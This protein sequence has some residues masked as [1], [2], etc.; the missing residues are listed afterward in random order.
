MSSPERS[1]RVQGIIKHD[2]VRVGDA[3]GDLPAA[4]PARPGGAGGSKSGARCK[5]SVQ[6]LREKDVV[7]AIEVRCSCGEVTVIEFEYGPREG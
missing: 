5:P 4:L 6:L 1:M 7:H 3:Q 2:R